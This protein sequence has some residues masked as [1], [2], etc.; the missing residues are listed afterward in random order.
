MKNINK[1]YMISLGTKNPDEAK[2]HVR[3][4]KSLLSLSKLSEKK[5]MQFEMRLQSLGE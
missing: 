3:K 4:S 1:S 2:V 5:T